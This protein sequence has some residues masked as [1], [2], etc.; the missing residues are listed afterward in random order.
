MMPMTNH[1]IRFIQ[2]T[3]VQEYIDNE[4]KRAER[5]KEQPLKRDE[6]GNDD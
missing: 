6:T 2:I 4:K 5:K 1:M 3:L